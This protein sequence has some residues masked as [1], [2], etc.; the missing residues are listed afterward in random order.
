VAYELIEHLKDPEIF[1]T[2]MLRILRDDGT[3]LVSTP[4]KATF[5]PNTDIYD[6]PNEFHVRE[7][8]FDQFTE[9]LDNYFSKIEMF[10]EHTAP[11][12]LRYDENM[13]I[14]N[15]NMRNLDNKIS[16]LKKEI[17]DLFCPKIIRRLIPQFIRDQFNKSLIIKDSVMEMESNANGCRAGN[18]VHTSRVLRAVRPPIM[19]WTDIHITQHNFQNCLYF[20]AVCRK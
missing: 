1:L 17:V 19:N 4:N 6:S 5:S 20:L 14:I 16:N 12:F 11:S 13:K 8:Y 3:F 15:E 9:L 18:E 2:E 10:A 7:Y